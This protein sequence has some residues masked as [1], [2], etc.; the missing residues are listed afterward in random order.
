MPILAI[1]TAT[2]V[3]SVA[4]CTKETL[5][6]ELTIQTQKTHSET[7][8]PHIRDVLLLAG[9]DKQD[10]QAIAVSIGPGSFTGLRIGLATAKAM[11][12]ALN[13][14]ICGVSTM[15]AL[16]YAC[17]VPGMVL[18]PLLDA[19]KGNVY[20][21]LFRWRNGILEQSIPTRVV[22][23][24][25]A[26]TEMAAIPEPV[27][28]M[29]EAAVQHSRRILE[30]G[31]NLL[32]APPHL[33]MPRAAMVALLAH[34]FRDGGNTQNLMNLAPVYIRRSEA[35]ELWEKRQSAGKS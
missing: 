30:L 13:I 10:L 6:A 27:M 15:E 8:M 24:E 12:Y 11:A 25:A 26:L 5:L 22:D 16:A 19:Q 34:R 2:L 29:G 31:G 7:L 4:V 21:A 33:I 32:L 1:D 28:V 35:E 3:S 14:P 18:A 9:V 23:L 20:Q 17:P